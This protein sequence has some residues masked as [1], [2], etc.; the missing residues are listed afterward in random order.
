M[1]A[2]L[3]VLGAAL[4]VTS[5]LQRRQIVR[6]RRETAWLRKT[7]ADLRAALRNA[8]RGRQ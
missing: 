5:L 4:T 1:T 8:L 2:A 3:L 6:L 7:N